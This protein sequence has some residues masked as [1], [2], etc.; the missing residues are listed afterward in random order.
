MFRYFA[1]TGERVVVEAQRGVGGS[2]SGLSEST[3][4]VISPPFW[5][6]VAPLGRGHSPCYD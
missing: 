4:R 5:Q 1:P 2:A 6:G 3:A